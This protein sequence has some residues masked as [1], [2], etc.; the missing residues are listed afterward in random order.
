VPGKLPGT[1]CTMRV[2]RLIE[3]LLSARPISK[4]GHLVVTQACPGR[5]D[6]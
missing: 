6:L 3:P 5:G 4:D 2:T 1:T